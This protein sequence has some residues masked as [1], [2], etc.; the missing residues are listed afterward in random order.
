MFLRLAPV[1]V[2]ALTAWGC[3]P[4][5][6]T[7]TPNGQDAGVDAGVNVTSDAGVRL[8]PELGTGDR[9][10]GSVTF[11]EIAN[12]DSGLRRPRDLAFNPMRPD[13]LW[14]VN[15]DDDSMV[16]VFDASTDARTSEKR[17]DPYA[18]HFMAFPS[19]IAFGSE[20]TTIGFPGTF[21]TCQE[22]RNTY[23]DQAPPNDFMGPALWS[24][25]LSIFASTKPEHNPLG[26]GTHLDMLH[27]SPNCMGIA[28]ERDHIYW[29]FGGKK[30]SG[31]TS[32]ER[33]E[34][35]PAIVKYDF[36]ADHGIGMDDHSDGS[37]YQYLTNEVA[38]IPGIPSHMA[39]DPSD[40]TLYIADTGNARIIA[41]DTRSGTMGPSLQPQEPLVAYRRVDNATVVDI[42]PNTS[43]LAGIPSGL[44]LQNELIY[45]SDNNG[46][47]ISAFTKSGELVNHLDTGLPAGSLSG[48]AFGPDGKLYFVD[49]LGNR[50]LRIDPR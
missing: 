19:S 28:W 7:P 8:A 36:G 29:A 20:E 12:F 38:S 35:I 1:A 10:P 39:F 3:N 31:T 46:S 42:V 25:D 37:I 44:E 26:L 27:G 6:Q 30:Q 21:G 11:T 32:K 34:P 18:T 40:S 17:I 23:G 45:S 49:M 16:I 33:Q 2:L 24:S 43:P 41:L 47:R 5:D 50:V 14:I 4:P 22:S 9:S 15:Y 48:M 13:E